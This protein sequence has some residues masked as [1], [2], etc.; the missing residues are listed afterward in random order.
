MVAG[1]GDDGAEVVQ[2]GRGVE[3]LPL[4]GAVPVQRFQ[5]V[6]QASGE[7]ADVVGMLLLVVVVA[8]DVEDAEAAHVRDD[9]EGQV[10]PE[11]LEEEPLPQPAGRDRQVV[12]AEAVEHPGQ[13]QGPGEDDVG[14]V[15]TDPGQGLARLQIGP[16]EEVNR[17]FDRASGQA[18]AV[19]GVEGVALPRRLDLGEVADGPA[20]SD[21]SAGLSEPRYRIE[22]RLDLQLQRPSLFGRD[23]VG[24]HEA[25]GQ[26]ERPEGARFPPDVAPVPHLAHLDAA[27]P[28]VEDCAV[29]QG[30]VVQGADR[31]VVGFALSV[32]DPQVEPDLV[33]DPLHESAPVGGVAHGAG[34]RRQHDIGPGALAE[35]LEQPQGRDCPGRGF[36]GEPLLGHALAQAHDLADLVLQAVRVPGD[37]GDQNQAG[38]VGAEVDYRDVIG[39]SVHTGCV[40]L[41]DAGRTAPDMGLSGDVFRKERSIYSVPCCISPGARAPPEGSGRK[42]LR[43]HPRKHRTAIEI[44][45]VRGQTRHYTS[46]RS[47]GLDQAFRPSGPMTSKRAQRDPGRSGKVA[48]SKVD[49]C[50]RYSVP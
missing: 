5:L 11:V 30:D 23:R 2:Q 48:S 10:L 25:L 3:H 9:G 46:L 39:R 13:H 22:L 21:K 40:I 4:P 27:A 36:L 50:S 41:R 31:A 38:G 34:R 8:R 20:Q 1:V 18:E 17:L 19:Q 42:S 14:A 44:S 47:R 33:A 28:D 24:A 26:G 6:E 7:V 16:A 43:R 37:G 12:E 49:P 32:E 29:A 15:R 45:G 35:P